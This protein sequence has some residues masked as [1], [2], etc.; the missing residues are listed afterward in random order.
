MYLPIQSGLKDARANREL[1]FAA[2]LEVLCT[3]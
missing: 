3:L 1:D 2:A